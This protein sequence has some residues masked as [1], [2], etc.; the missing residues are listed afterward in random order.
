[1]SIIS[2]CESLLHQKT[3]GKTHYYWLEANDLDLTCHSHGLIS[4]LVDKEGEPGTGIKP[5]FLNALKSVY[6][7][8]FNPGSTILFSLTEGA[9]GKIAVYNRKGQFVGAL[10]WEKDYQKELITS[11]I[12]M[13]KTRAV[14]AS[15]PVFTYLSYGQIKDLSKARK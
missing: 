4:A 7:N 5:D 3:S 12:V 9:I 15:F 1:M 10:V 2:C 14:T 8:L 11:N 13:V 6:P